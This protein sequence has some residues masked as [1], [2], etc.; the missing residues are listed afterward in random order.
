M[1]FFLRSDS[2]SLR[3]IPGEA[4][5]ASHPSGLLQLPSFGKDINF[6]WQ[7]VLTHFFLVN[8]ACRPSLLIL[9]RPLAFL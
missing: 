9:T 5:H 4:P 7:R 3:T 2:M 1:L 6:P 8:T